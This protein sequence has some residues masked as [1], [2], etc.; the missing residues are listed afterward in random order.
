MYRS[1]RTV[2]SF[3]AVLVLT[4]ASSG[5]FARAA[6]LQPGQTQLAQS[7]LAQTNEALTIDDL[8]LRGD[9]FL[10]RHDISSAR[11]FYELAATEG[12]AQAAA[13]L[14]MTY[15]PF[16]LQSLGVR[17][18]VGD[19]QSAL[20][21]YGKAV[22]RGDREATRRLDRLQ[23]QM[24]SREPVE[25]APVPT[26][27]ARAVRAQPGKPAAAPDADVRVQLAAAKSEH[28]ALI[29]AVRLRVAYPDLLGDKELLVQHLQVSGGSDGAFG[30]WSEPL[31]GKP[32]AERLCA[33][34][35]A[36]SQNCFLVQ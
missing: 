20:D 15:D 31:G 30:V 14:G 35:Q 36:K 28:D 23:A 22:N 9:E 19:A 11:L 8:I 10:A 1:L 16:Y 32:D 24:L 6:S 5:E 13:K 34:L 3:A 29:E 12:H 26:S 33:A 18:Y 27:L 7:Q 4:Q 25:A 17:G 21:W 2:L